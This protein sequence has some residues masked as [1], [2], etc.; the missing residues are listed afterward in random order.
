MKVE[1]FHGIDMVLNYP[2]CIDGQ[3]NCPPEDCG[4]I[5]SFYHC[6]DVL[7]DKRHPDHKEVNQW[8]DKKN[9]PEQFD[10]EKINRKL[11][12]LTQSSS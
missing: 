4:G 8:F 6:I 7:K 3:M 12:K 9:K 5:G 10:M 1:K 2:T 11:K